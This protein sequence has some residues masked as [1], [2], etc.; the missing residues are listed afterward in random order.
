VA[1]RIRLNEFLIGVEG[2]ALMRELFT[3]SDEAAGRRID[4]VRRILS[5]GETFDRASDVPELDVTGGYARWS[6]TYDAP[7]N[8]LVSA[9]QPAVWALLDAAEPGRAL[10][11]ACGTGR[12]ARRLIER[13]HNVTGLDATP[14]MLARAR[15]AVP[16]AEYV[17]ADLNAL[18]FEDSSFDLAVC[19]LALAHAERLAPPLAELGRVVRPGGR[20]IVSDIHPI[21]SELG[22]VAYFVDAAGVSGFVRG[23]RHAHGDYLDAF[24]AAGLHV[25]RCI[26]PRFGRAEAEMQQPAASFVP[27]ATSAAFLDLPAAVVWELT[28]GPGPR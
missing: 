27:E 20:V 8:P 22:G 2:L 10:D 26:E 19:A 17:L 3:G 24:A 18:P 28:A 6:T 11:A 21:L 13:G 4:E 7:G 23:Y 14:E 5:D 15:D 16:E 1:R 12:H 25:E 9:E